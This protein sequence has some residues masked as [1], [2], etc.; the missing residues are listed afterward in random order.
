MV[1]I[2]HANGR[3]NM[4]LACKFKFRL[5]LSRN[6]QK[7]QYNVCMITPEESDTCDANKQEPSET[8]LPPQPHAGYAVEIVFLLFSAIKDEMAN[9][10]ERMSNRDHWQPSANYQH[11]CVSVHVVSITPERH[12]LQQC[13]VFQMATKRFARRVTW[14]VFTK[15]TVFNSMLSFFG[16]PLQLCRLKIPC[17][18]QSANRHTPMHTTGLFMAS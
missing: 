4:S 5:G 6:N 14:S 8:C 16:G 15:L 13:S 2:N 18:P 11:L 9:P 7:L 10:P 3:V 1:D 12:N 17:F